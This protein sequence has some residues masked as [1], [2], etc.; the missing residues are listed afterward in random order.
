[1]CVLVT[2]KWHLSAV[3]VARRS[4]SSWKRSTGLLSKWGWGQRCLRCWRLPLVAPQAQGCAWLEGEPAGEGVRRRGSEGW[5]AGHLAAAGRCVPELGTRGG[6]PAGLSSHSE[7]PLHTDNG[8]QLLRMNNSGQQE[9]ENPA[10]ERRQ[11]GSE[12]APAPPCSDRL[13]WNF[14]S[15][16]EPFMEEGNRQ[17]RNGKLCDGSAEP[18]ASSTRFKDLALSFFLA[19]N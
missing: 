2:E 6:H 8:A 3:Q 10:Q 1:M 5:Q 12:A 17:S 13:R 11:E 9:T 15:R 14:L 19:A 4:V 16:C 18:A 7:V